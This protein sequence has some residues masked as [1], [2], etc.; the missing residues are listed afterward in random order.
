MVEKGGGD[1]TVSAT[2]S[3]LAASG[4]HTQVSLSW[5]AL[6]ADTSHTQLGSPTERYVNSSVTNATKYFYVVSG[7]LRRTKR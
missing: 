7:E 1:V 2:P 6:S 4:S 3:E 5:S